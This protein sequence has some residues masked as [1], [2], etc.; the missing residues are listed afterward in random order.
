MGT[1]SHGAQQHD[2]L[3]SRGSASTERAGFATGPV[4][5]RAR[6]LVLCAVGAAILY[7]ALVASK[8]SCPSGSTTD[9]G[10]LDANGNPTTVQPQCVTL[11]LQPSPVIYLAIALTV[12]IALSRA[13]HSANL[14]LALRTMN[15]GAMVAVAIAVTSMLV[16]IV[17]FQL[18]P[19]PTVSGTVL[20]PFPFGSGTLT[21]TPQEPGYPG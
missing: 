1:E 18:S 12:I 3:N 21:V 20:F 4:L 8:G 15:R 9:G 16:A 5:R 14:E 19:M 17:W 10:F 2:D 7:S 11:G 6:A 13:A